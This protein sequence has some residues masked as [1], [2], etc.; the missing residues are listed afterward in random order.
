MFY[1]LDIDLSEG[2]G[3][4]RSVISQEMVVGGQKWGL[5]VQVDS[6]SNMSLFMFHGG[7]PDKHPLNFSSI[8]FEIVVVAD[9]ETIHRS[10]VFF[11]Y[12]REQG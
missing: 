2:I 10:R 11:S 4:N 9:S 12:S 5:V 1:G 6:S 7:S 8:L 3:K